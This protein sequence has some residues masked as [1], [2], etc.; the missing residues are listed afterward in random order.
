MVD[1]TKD[2]LGV[3]TKAQR[4]ELQ[5]NLEAD[6]KAAYYT[7]Y[8]SY[9]NANIAAQDAARRVVDAAEVSNDNSI[10]A[11]IALNGV[12]VELIGAIVPKTGAEKR[13]RKRE[14][15]L[16]NLDSV[17]DGFLSAIGGAVCK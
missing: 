7:A 11:A 14:D 2:A 5:K 16:D 1:A 12:T 6:V 4:E 8:S 10:Q 17:V 9:K 13:E 3:L 15:S